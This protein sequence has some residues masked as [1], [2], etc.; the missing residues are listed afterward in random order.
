MSLVPGR[1]SWGRG[2]SCPGL[3]VQEV[4]IQVKCPG[5]KGL[6]GNCPGE[7]FLRGHCQE[8]N[9]SGVIVRG[10]KLRR[11]TVLEEFHRR[12]LFGGLLSKEKLFRGDCPG[13]KSLGGNRPGGNFIGEQLPEGQLPREECPDTYIYVGLSVC[14][15]VCLYLSICMY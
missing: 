6:G 14:R 9:C 4:I 7:S 11:V 13:C 3:V 10:A 5:G 1:I 12:Q 15:S 2:G 8:G